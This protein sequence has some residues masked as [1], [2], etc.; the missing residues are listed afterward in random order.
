VIEEIYDRAAT[1]E[2][3]NKQKDLEISLLNEEARIM[4]TPLTDNMDLTHR[5]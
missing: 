3:D 1:K 4:V 2:V 5:A